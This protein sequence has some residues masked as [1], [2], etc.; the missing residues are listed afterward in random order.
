MYTPTC[1][2]DIRGDRYCLPVVHPEETSAKNIKK[3]ESAPGTPGW[4][5]I[6]FYMRE[7]GLVSVKCALLFCDPRLTAVQWHIS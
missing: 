4:Y 7:S 1:S 2:D 3:V 6:P 5:T